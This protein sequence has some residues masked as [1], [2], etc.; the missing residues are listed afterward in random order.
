M[1]LT[2]FLKIREVKEKFRET[3]KRPSMKLEG[4]LLAPSQTKNYGLVGTA[5]D[6]LM[7]FILEYHNPTAITYPWVAEQVPEKLENAV[8]RGD[9]ERGRKII[10]EIKAFSEEVIEYA[11]KHYQEFLK[12]GQID[13][14]LLQACLLLAQTDVIF[15]SGNHP[16]DYRKVE[17]G[18]MDD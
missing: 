9:V 12:T 8:I 16:K 2:A 4:K 18:D 11:K 13:G 1:S 10:S 7:R 6:Y 5:F 3:F 14:N 15:R 17:E